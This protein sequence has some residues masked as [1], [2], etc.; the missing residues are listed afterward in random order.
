[1]NAD[2]IGCLENINKS[3]KIFEYNGKPMT[4]EQVKKCL[5]YGIRKGYD[6]TGQLSE[7]DIA[8]ALKINLIDVVGINK[9]IEK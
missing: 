7:L 4:K 3:W 5:I 1:M 6:H 9:T 8:D 2:L